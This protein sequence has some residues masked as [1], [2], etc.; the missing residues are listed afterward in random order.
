MNIEL[1][2]SGEERR[3]VW[4]TSTHSALKLETGGLL[5]SA[6]T[7]SHGVISQQTAA[8]RV[9]QYLWKIWGEAAGKVAK[10]SA[11]IT[12]PFAHFLRFR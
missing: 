3:V 12:S 6:P 11:R 9:L 7:G 4:Y 5:L 8:Q 1:Q 2:S 10:R